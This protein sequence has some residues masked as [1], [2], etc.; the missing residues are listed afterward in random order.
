[1]ASDYDQTISRAF[2]LLTAKVQEAR[3][4][5]VQGVKLRQAGRGFLGKST[6]DAQQLGQAMIADNVGLAQEL[7][8]E[9]DRII[10]T[11]GAD[12]P[13]DAAEKLAEPFAEM[14]RFLG[15]LP[16]TS[17]KDYLG[18]EGGLNGIA[19]VRIKMVWNT[20]RIGLEQ[21]FTLMVRKHRAG[22]QAKAAPASAGRSGRQAVNRKVQPVHF[23]DFSGREFE[24]LV[25]A[26]ALREGWAKVEWLGEAGA[27]GGR[28]IWC[29]R[30]D[31]TTSV[32]LCANFKALRFAKARS[33]LKKL[34]R[35]E[36]KPG[37]V[38]VI[39]GGSVG[40]SLR[41]KISGEAAKLGFGVCTV[42]SGAELEEHIRLK[43]E[44][45]LERFCHGEPFP[46]SPEELAAFAAGQ[47]A[48]AAAA[49][50]SDLDP[51]Q[52]SDEAKKLLFEMSVAEDG[53]VLR[54]R[55]H[56][57][58]ALTINQREFLKDT[59]ERRIVA[60]WERAINEL[61][62]LDL[63]EHEGSGDDLLVITDAGYQAVDECG[64][65]P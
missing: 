12:V 1:M 19:L 28:D 41:G 38:R 42:W 51:E 5:Q 58:Y 52:L 44:A 57:G 33:D 48:P 21:E 16:V 10:S 29:T 9:L 53:N 32:I 62:E 49:R 37:E 64:L 40:V 25:F 11:G 45:L 56:D 47:V 65:I 2:A 20:A 50:T 7:I 22:Q 54:S 39:G 46:D 55:T 14:L 27:D 59:K 26:F 17:A 4:R 43:A 15:E 18:G 35:L 8:R 31:G 36:T 13:A 30:A 6:G 34:A 23:E 60:K 61:L 63:I 24:R 3:M